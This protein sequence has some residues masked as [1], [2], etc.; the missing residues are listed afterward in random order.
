MLDDAERA[1]ALRFCRRAVRG[2]VPV[3]GNVGCVTTRAG[4]NLARQAEA[5]GIEFLVVIT[6]YYIKLSPDELA[7]HYIEI[8]RAVRTPVLAYNIPER[9]G[10]ELTREIVSRGASACENFAGLKDSGGKLD[11]TEKFI[12][13]A[14][15]RKLAVFIGRD[16]IILPALQ[17]GCVG[18][19]TACSNVAPRL[20][21]HLYQAFQQGNLEE[22]ARLQELVN[23]LRMAFGQ[24]TVPS[25]IKEAMEL[26]GLPAGPCRKT[27]GPMPPTARADLSRVLDRLR[28][29]N[30][31]P[32]S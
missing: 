32:K 4:V 28:A 12:E 24:H 22:A 20:F 9:T 31:S 17:L 1:E 3:Y 5:D 7:A 19:V 13:P 14:P 29:E 27:V 15:G 6:P 23:P 26:V 2:R 18:A 21:V 11:L 10:N 16:H 8:C 30:F 25:V